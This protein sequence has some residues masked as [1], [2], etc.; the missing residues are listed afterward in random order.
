MCVHLSITQCGIAIMFVLLTV[1]SLYMRVSMCTCYLHYFA[2]MYACF[3]VYVH[4]FTC[5]HDVTTCTCGI[6]IVHVLHVNVTTCICL[7]FFVHVCAFTCTCTIFTDYVR[8]ST[9]IC[10]TL[11]VHVS[12][13][14]CRC[15]LLK[16]TRLSFFVLEHASACTPQCFYVYVCGFVCTS[17]YFYE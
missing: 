13:S 2:C 9:Y 8:V 1:L 3:Y 6:W 17:T 14:T 5:K 11:F 7:L 16:R 4:V 12:V 15:V 10:V